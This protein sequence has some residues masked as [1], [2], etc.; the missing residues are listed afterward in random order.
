MDWWKGTVK[1]PLQSS[2]HA[3]LDFVSGC[4]KSIAYSINKNEEIRNH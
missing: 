4:V 3:P 2:D 1:L